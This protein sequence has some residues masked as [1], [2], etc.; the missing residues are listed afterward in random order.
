[1]QNGLKKAPCDGKLTPETPSWNNFSFCLCRSYAKQMSSCERA[2]TIETVTRD[3][4]K[5]MF[6]SPVRLHLRFVKLPK[7]HTSS[8]ISVLPQR[9][10]A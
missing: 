7:N 10:G 9:I 5:V 1:M 2:V 3:A 6:I 8:V 4:L